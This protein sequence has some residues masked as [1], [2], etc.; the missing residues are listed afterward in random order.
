LGEE[1]LKTEIIAPDYG[2]FAA[3]QEEVLRRLEGDGAYDDQSVIIIVPTLTPIH[4]RV[5]SSWMNMFYPPNQ[6]VYRVFPY[7][8]EVGAAYSSVIEQVLAH[9]ALSQFRYLLTLE[10]DNV[11]QPDSLVRLLVRARANPHLSAIGGLYFTKGIGGVAQIWG[12]PKE[13]MNFRPQL[14]RPGELVE[15]CGLGM[16]FTLFRM[17]MFKDARLRRPWFRTVA[18]YSQNEGAQVYTQDL[19]FW[20]DARRWGHRCAVDCATVVGH[21]ESATDT[22]W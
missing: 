18:Q 14:P 21:H 5:V 3:N 4:P 1:K 17:D 15:C 7:G 2:K 22:V 8:A 12:N 13:P 19:W 9:P 11:P 6:R 20:E 10:H 16:G